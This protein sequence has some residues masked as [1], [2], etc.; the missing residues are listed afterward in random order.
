MA[1]FL[2]AR[3]LRALLL[4]LVVSSAALLLVHLAPGD[5]FTR[6]D[7]DPSVARAERAR[8]GLDRPFLDQYVSWLS[9][10]ATFDFG[11]S[12][13]FRRPVAGLLA[14]RL[15]RTLLLGSCALLVAIVLGVPLGVAGAA[16]PDRWWTRTVGGLSI[17][18]ISV[19][20]LVMSLVL[21]LVAQ[22]TGW[23]PTGGLG[24]P[25]D[26][27]LLEQAA[28]TMRAMVLPV[29]ALA[30]P[31]AASVERLQQSAARD[32]FREPC[33]QAALA[34]GVTR[35]RAIWNHAFRLSLKPVIGILGIIVGSVLSGSFIVEI[36]MSWPGIGDLMYQ[37]LL[38]RDLYLAA[39]CAA[40]AS[41][42]LA[43][44]VFLA[45]LGL[46]AVDPRM[47]EVE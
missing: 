34:R 2:L 32:A 15:P 35:R 31:I 44:G 30:L 12:I 37:A 29:L 21:L 42:F 33:V 45:D 39:G 5:A 19:P 1:A 8:L 4:V 7:I 17:I 24:V 6:F 26:A 25:T 27:P 10:S 40:V 28:S 11:E 13:R 36:V 3:S 46:A 43:V 41:L 22:R 23:L 20:P 14:E 18:L 9:R 16:R 38:A 47:R